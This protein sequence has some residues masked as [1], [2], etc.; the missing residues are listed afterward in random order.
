[1]DQF[2]MNIVDWLSQFSYWGILLAL[3]IEF[4]PAEI[5]LPL[6]GLWVFEG[7]MNYYLAVLAGAVGGTLGPLT[8]Y[9]LGR[10]GGRPFLSRYGKFFFIKDE[11][12]QISDAFFS[13]HGNIVAFSG[14]FLPVVRTVISIPCGIG[15]M[16]VFKFAGFTF[17]AMLPI[18][19]FYVYLGVQFGENYEYIEHYAKTYL[20]PFGIAAILFV[21]GYVFIKN[22]KKQTNNSH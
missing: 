10:F 21:S 7:K 4:I 8:L 2:V 15:K 22:K 13:K 19:A 5:V 14:R 12:L 1:M 6:A 16:N 3:C 20:T 11:H 17:C 9:A 18:T